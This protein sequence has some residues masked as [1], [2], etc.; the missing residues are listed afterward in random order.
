MKTMVPESAQKNRAVVEKYAHQLWNEKNL[1]A[2]DEFLAEDV[3]IHSPLGGFKGKS[4]MR[5]IVNKWLTAFPDLSMENKGVLSDGDD[6]ALHWAAKGTH[7]GEFRGK[8]PTGKKVAY[9][10]VTIYRVKDG[11]IKE[12]WAYIDMQHLADQL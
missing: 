2:I 3:I 5:E 6:V 8:K 9:S 7:K 10:G 11:K 1:H 12:Y 4:S